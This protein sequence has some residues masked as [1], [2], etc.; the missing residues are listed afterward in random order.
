M[1]HY[2]FNKDLSEKIIKLHFFPFLKLF[3]YLLKKA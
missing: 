3:L 2:L 1:H